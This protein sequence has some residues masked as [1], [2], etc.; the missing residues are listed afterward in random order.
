MYPAAIVVIVNLHRS[1]VDT[2]VFNTTQVGDNI[3]RHFSDTEDRPATAG[4]LSF[5]LSP[6]TKESQDDTL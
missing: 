3:G 6:P 1:V 2:Y 4:H 5:A